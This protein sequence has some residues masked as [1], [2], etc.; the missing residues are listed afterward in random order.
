MYEKIQ[1]LVLAATYYLKSKSADFA[2]RS[3]LLRL[4]SVRS[5]EAVT[6]LLTHFKY[7]RKMQWVLN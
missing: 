4:R 1:H 5:C 3:H 2:R 7:H 6:R